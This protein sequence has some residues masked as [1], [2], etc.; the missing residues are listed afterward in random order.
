VFLIGKDGGVKLTERSDHVS[1]QT[2]FALIDSMPM[3]QR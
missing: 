1:L 2:L 3:R